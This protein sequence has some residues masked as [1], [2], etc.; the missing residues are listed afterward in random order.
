MIHFLQLH[1][2]QEHPD[3]PMLEHVKELCAKLEELGIKPS[4]DDGA[5]EAQGGWEDVEDVEDS[6]DDVE[7]S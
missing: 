6:D 7:M 3:R 5:D 2:N 4:E 1:V